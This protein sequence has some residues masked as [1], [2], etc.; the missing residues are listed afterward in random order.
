[1][2]YKPYLGDTSKVN[3]FIERVPLLAEL[4]SKP[5]QNRQEGAR[6]PI[7]NRRLEYRVVE[8]KGAKYNVR[9][10]PRCSENSYDRGARR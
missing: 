6:C 10:C 1:M 8:H 3:A 4:F 2:R 9:V 5:R 7:C